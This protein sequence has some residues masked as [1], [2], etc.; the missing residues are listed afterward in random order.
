M[1]YKRFNVLDELREV[2]RGRKATI[3]PYGLLRIIADDYLSRVA[4][5]DDGVYWLERLYRSED[6]RMAELG[7]ES[8]GRIGRRKQWMIAR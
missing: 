3:D 7:G 6:P 4:D 2:Q 1:A 8:N 5:D